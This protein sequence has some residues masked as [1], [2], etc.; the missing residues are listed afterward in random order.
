MFSVL[1]GF[2]VIHGPAKSC[3]LPFTPSL[4]NKDFLATNKIEFV[5]YKPE[6]FPRLV[7]HISYW[8]NYDTFQIW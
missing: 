6:L 4:F 1:A 3:Q 7:L 8:S 2:R 5:E